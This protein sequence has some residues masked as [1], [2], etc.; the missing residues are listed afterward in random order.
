MARRVSYNNP[1]NGSSP[2]NTFIHTPR[3]VSNVRTPANVALF[4]W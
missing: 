3:R 4:F 1:I 2:F